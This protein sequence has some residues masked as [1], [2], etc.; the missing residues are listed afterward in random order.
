MAVVMFVFLAMGAIAYFRLF[1]PS[2][3]VETS[4]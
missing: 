3:E 4:T 1:N 2:E